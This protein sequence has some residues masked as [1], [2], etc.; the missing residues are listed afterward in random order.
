MPEHRSQTVENIAHA[1]VRRPFEAGRGQAVA[2]RWISSRMEVQELTYQA[3]EGASSRVAGALRRLGI[4]PGQTACTFLPRSPELVESLFGFLKNQ[5]VACILF[6]T[7]GENALFDRLDNSGVR[8]IVTKKSLLKRVVNLLERL[9]E[10]RYVLVTDLEEHLDQKVLSLPVLAAAESADFPFS[11]TLP[12]E[13]P[14][15]LQYT[16]GSTGRPKGALH[17]HGGLVSMQRSFSDVMQ[18]GADDVYW[19]TADPAWI[20]G[21]VYGIFAPLSMGTRQIQFGGNYNAAAW[22]SILQDQ[23]VSVWYTAPTALRMLMQEDDALFS[24][25]R[26]P[27]LKRIYSVGEP[28]NAEV[29]RWGRRIFGQEIFDTWFQS[30]TG[31]ILIA[32]RP[33]MAIKPGSMGKPLPGIRATI[34]AETLDEQS[35]GRQGHLC[36]DKGWPSM[37]R[38]YFG[39]QVLYEEKFYGKHYLTGDLAWKDEDG[40]YWY[41]SRADDVINTGGHLVG[42]FEVESALLEVDGVTDVA[43]IGVPDKILHERIVAY[44]CLKKGQ[45]WSRAFELKC[46]VTVSNRVST[47]ATPQEFHVVDRILKNKSGKILR[48]V[49]KA[50]YEGKDPGDLSTLEER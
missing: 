25:Y 19:C 6:A 50:L 9:P 17:V 13:T 3:L 10:L 4:T 46:R 30:E 28:L 36:V 7:F 38:A 5:A 35:A 42:P 32:N 23:H 33:G 8:V 41:V 45:E 29:Y 15:F 18:L 1:C 12:A 31:S 26:L 27:S 44:L 43:V 2:F 48:R 37:F 20:T 34:L 40:Y 47:A 49:L 24:E 22:L 39:S 11:P 14:A 21:L 16:S